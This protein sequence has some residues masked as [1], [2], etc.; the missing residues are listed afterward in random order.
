M[1]LLL[2]IPFGLVRGQEV[3]KL[4]KLRLI[5]TLKSRVTY[6]VHVVI[7]ARLHHSSS[8][9]AFIYLK[10]TSPGDDRLADNDQRAG[11]RV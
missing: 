6:T 11:R 10:K 9:G 1:M 4:L 8:P 5:H 3:V 7:S 2:N